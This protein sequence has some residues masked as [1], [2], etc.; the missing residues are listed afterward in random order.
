MVVN[1]EYL[2]VGP[3]ADESLT[4]SNCQRDLGSEI[5]P[6]NGTPTT[7]TSEHL[8]CPAYG[9]NEFPV[10]PHACLRGSFNCFTAR[11]EEKKCILRRCPQM[12]LVARFSRL[13]TSRAESCS[14]FSR[15]SSIHLNNFWNFCC[16]QCRDFS[17]KQAPFLFVVRGGGSVGCSFR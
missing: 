10:P 15:H 4:I 13:A 16:F 3:R 5:F 9:A 14:S 1:P 8:R 7:L 11:R 6:L 2:Y 17:S 12:Y